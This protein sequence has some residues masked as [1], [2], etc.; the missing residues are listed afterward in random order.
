V[1]NPISADNYVAEPPST[2]TVPASDQ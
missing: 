1:R 2:V